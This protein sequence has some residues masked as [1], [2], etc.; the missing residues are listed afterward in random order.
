ELV[1]DT[2]KK[3][4][5]WRA[6]RAPGPGR[7]GE[8][9]AWRRNL[10]G[11]LLSSVG[12]MVLANRANSRDG[13]PN[14][15]SCMYRYMNQCEIGRQN[16]TNFLPAT[17]RH[18]SRFSRHVRVPGGATLGRKASPGRQFA[19]PGQGGQPP[20]PN[21]SVSGV[22]SQTRTLPSSEALIRRLPF[23]TNRIL[24]TG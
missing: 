21:H 3:P 14:R 8:G 1:C 5:P 24:C 4:S 23:E 9:P 10:P 19:R 22:A 18:E 7:A 11:R 15:C 20:Y 17:R 16:L 6:D 2:M 12:K 13:L